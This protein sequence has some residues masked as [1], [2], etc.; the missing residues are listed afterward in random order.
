M[1]KNISN[2]KLL[3]LAD[4]STSIHDLCT[5]IGYSDKEINKKVKKILTDI[6]YDLEKFKNKNNSPL[7]DKLKLEKIV[8]E[9]FSYKEVLSKFNLSHH[10]ET[11]KN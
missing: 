9:S 3:L 2:E 7:N 4:N 11:L 8:K 5:K 10:T 1:F 6:G